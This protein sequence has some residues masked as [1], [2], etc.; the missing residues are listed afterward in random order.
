MDGFVEGPYVV[1]KKIAYGYDIYT[2]K[3]Y[4]FIYNGKQL[5]IRKQIGCAWNTDN[6][7]MT[8]VK[9]TAD[10]FACSPDMNKLLEDIL[11]Y[12]DDKQLLTGEEILF[13]HRIR[14]V[15]EVIR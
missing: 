3:K 4:P 9:A 7:D 8:K 10:L 1:G 13:Q 12:Y 5:E 6:G 14:R 11:S 2:E 15:L